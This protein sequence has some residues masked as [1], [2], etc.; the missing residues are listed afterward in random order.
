M[1]GKVN[2]WV[3][4]HAWLAV[5]IG[6]ILGMSLGAAATKVDP[7][8]EK[9]SSVAAE[10]EE[11][12]SEE[13]TSETTTPTTE[14]VAPVQEDPEVRFSQTCDY[15]LS[16]EIYGDISLIGDSK[17]RNTGNVGVRGKIIFR[18]NQ[19]GAAPIKEEKEFRLEVGTTTHVRANLKYPY[20]GE[21]GD[22]VD[23]IQALPY[24]D[25]CKV[26]AVL[27]DTFGEPVE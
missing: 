26:N 24:D 8:E 4:E 23:R 15:L 2:V 9:T 25:H 13:E 11:S 20:Q 17:V 10:P 3:R 6:L 16:N 21:G 14:Y 19:A 1:W 12:S 7:A 22:I 18:W 27:T 5:G